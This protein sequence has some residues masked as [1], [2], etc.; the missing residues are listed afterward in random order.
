MR[1]DGKVAL[2]TGAASGIG[3]QSAQ[4]FAARGARV[5]VVDPLAYDWLTHLK[6][7]ALAFQEALAFKETR[8]NG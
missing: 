3:R 2:I 6:G 4:L 8:R 1:L 5:V 7:V